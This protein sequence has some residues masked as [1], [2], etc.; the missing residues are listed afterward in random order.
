MPSSARQ[1]SLQGM[2]AAVS[3]AALAMAAIR[4]FEPATWIVLG[5]MLTP[6]ALTLWQTRGTAWPGVAL[7]AALAAAVAV[8]L[9]PPPSG[10]AFLVATGAWLGGGTH[11]LW[12][13]HVRWGALVM[14]L[15]V[16]GL[17]LVLLPPL[18]TQ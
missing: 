11:A 5:V 2:L 4:W 1:F 7:G 13:G 16:A 18:T 8:P 6:V 12:L 10:A 17:A 3:V 14:L 15:A 9:G